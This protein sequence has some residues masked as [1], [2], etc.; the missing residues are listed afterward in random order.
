[1]LNAAEAAMDAAA[2]DDAARERNRTILY[3]PPRGARR[4]PDGRR[5]RAPGRSLDME[6]A[7]ALAAQVAAEDARLTRASTG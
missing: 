7:R 1:M 6:A 3:A 2:E 5:A 4:G